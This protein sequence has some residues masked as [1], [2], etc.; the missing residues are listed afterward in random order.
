MQY[1][2][3]QHMHTFPVNTGMYI[4]ITNKKYEKYVYVYTRLVSVYCTDIA[5][6][7]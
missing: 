4:M 7:T 5:I 1:T 3:V 6:S 2:R